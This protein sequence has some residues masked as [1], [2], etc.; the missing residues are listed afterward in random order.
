DLN[1]AIA[2]HT[3]ILRRL[4]GEDIE[5]VMKVEPGLKS[6]KADP[7]QLEQVIMNLAVNARDAM[8]IGGKLT[9]QAANIYLDKRYALKRVPVKPGWYVVLAV[10]DTGCGMN[11]ETQSRIFE[12][13]FTTKEQGKGTGLGLSTVYGIIKQSGGQIRVHSEP[14]RGST[15]TLYLPCVEESSGRASAKQEDVQP[16]GN[17]T[18]MVVE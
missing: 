6:I 14:G 3:K 11:A 9:I 1:A 7:G 4:I 12:P 5:L 2:D 10:S 13:F 17:E 8:P 18:I 16:Q 15:F